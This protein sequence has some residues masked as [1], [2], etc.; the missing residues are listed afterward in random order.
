[1]RRNRKIQFFEAHPPHPNRYVE[2]GAHA[3]CNERMQAQRKGHREDRRRSATNACGLK[4][5]KTQNTPGV[6]GV[7]G[8]RS[9]R[10]PG[11]ISRR[12]ETHVKDNLQYIPSYINVNLCIKS[13]SNANQRA[14]REGIGI[15]NVVKSPMSRREE[16]RTS[17]R[18]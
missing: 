5:E 14:G 12:T 2:E 1:M 7:R 11:R 8:F 16:A 3:Q 10:T 15:L 4:M 18:G 13:T 6:C 9:H 17:V